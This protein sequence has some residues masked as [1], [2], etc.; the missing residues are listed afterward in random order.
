MRTISLKLSR[1][2]LRCGNR[3]AP[4]Y[5]RFYIWMFLQLLLPY[6]QE[7]LLLYSLYTYIFVYLYSFCVA[8]G[9][10]AKWQRRVKNWHGFGVTL[11]EWCWL[12]LIY[13]NIAET[14]VCG[15]I[16]IAKT[17]VYVANILR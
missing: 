4:P 10:M 7:L 2:Q 1:V 16:K 6:V 3:K 17:L 12:L 14:F 5:A 11:M 8:T 9:R 15:I 13:E